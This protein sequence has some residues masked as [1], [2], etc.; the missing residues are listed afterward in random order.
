MASS[1]DDVQQNVMVDAFAGED[2]DDDGE[3]KEV[4]VPLFDIAPLLCQDRPRIVHQF[5]KRWQI[6]S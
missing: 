6:R 3:M 4:E 5:S 2:D 1:D